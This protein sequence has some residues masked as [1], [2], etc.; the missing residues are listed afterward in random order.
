MNQLTKRFPLVLTNYMDIEPFS[1][2]IKIYALPKEEEMPLFLQS[3]KRV[4]I[5]KQCGKLI[6]YVK[7][8]DRTRKSLKLFQLEGAIKGFFQGEDAFIYSL[9]LN[10]SRSRTVDATRE[11]WVMEQAAKVTKKAGR[12]LL[13]ANY[14]MRRPTEKDAE[15]MSRLY[16]SVFKTYPTP[17]H[18]PEFIRD[19]MKNQVFFTVIEHKGRIISAC[20]V[21]V[22]PAFQSAEMSDC[23]TME[24]HRNRGLLSYQ[25]SFLIRLMQKKGLWTLFS[26]SRSLSLGMNVVNVYH[27][28]T[29]GGRMICNSNISGQLES[30]NIWYKQ[31]RRT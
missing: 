22:L 7:K 9:F 24:E 18:D 27:G 6:L 14:T 31:L 21:D 25:F 17:M 15:E 4:A 1:E 29:Y 26:Y 3:L 13:P 16:R 12:P 20:S 28:F 19:V 8:Q 5:A 23:A 10:R 30:M 11:K 2:R